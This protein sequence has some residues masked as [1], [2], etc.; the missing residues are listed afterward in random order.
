MRA[1]PAFR[2]WHRWFGILGGAWL[3][4]LA[5]T[6]SA[7]AWYD[8]LDGVLNPDLRVAELTDGPPTSIDAVVASAQA[9]L[10]GFEPG[11]ILV[12]QSPDR[13]HWLLGRQT[14]Q[15]GSARPVQAFVDPG[16]G[17]F[18]G[19]RESGRLSLHRHYL[20][21]LIYGL[22]TD[23]LVG[24]IGV[25]FVGLLSLAWL[26][27]HFLSLP[28]AFPRLGK[29]LSAWRVGGH[30]GSLRRLWDRHRA[31]AMW[32]WPVTAVLALTGVTLSFPMESREVVETVTPVGERLHYDM[33]ERDPPA[34]PVTL[35]AAIAQVTGDRSSLHSVRLHPEVGLYAVRTFD[36][37]DVDNQGRLWT[38][39]D[40]ETG[41]I[42]ARRHDA[43]ES[44]GDTFFVWQYA[45]HS[46]HAFGLVGRILVTL[47]GLVT[48]Y[49]CFSGYRLW[50]RRRRGRPRTGGAA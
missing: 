13:T 31:S 19:W 1:R 29:W 46:G 18:A 50:W 44:A 20:P 26:L 8:E 4:L 15:D 35:E 49:L 21:D 39:V 36:G 3:L 7:I 12:S 5:L 25:I 24:E 17:E 14:L 6:G 10:P 45:L 23:L 48:A 30:A 40:M 38:Y 22:H 28:L 32:A 34:D 27:D 47:A 37:R 33:A 16:T 43:G 9:A 41:E 11:N 2:F 42:A